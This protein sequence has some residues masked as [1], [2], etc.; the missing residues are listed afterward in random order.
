MQQGKALTIQEIRSRAQAIKPHIRP[1]CLILQP[2]LE[3]VHKVSR[4]TVHVIS[5]DESGKYPGTVH[6]RELGF[7]HPADQFEFPD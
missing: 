3:M 4:C 7:W 2:P 6:T 5:I 1:G